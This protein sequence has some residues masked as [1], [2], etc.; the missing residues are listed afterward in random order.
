[1]KL[2]VLDLCAGAGG[3]SM[4]FHR[5]DCDVHGVEH[6]ADACETHRRMVGPCDNVDMREY[7]AR[8]GCWAMVIGGVPCQPHSEQGKKQGL[9]AEMGRLHQHMA[10]IAKEARAEAVVMENVPGLANA[11]R[12][13]PAAI[14]S[15]VNTFRLAGYVTSWKIVNAA[16]FGVPQRR[17]RVFVVGF[18]SEVAARRFRWPEPTHGKGAGLLPQVTVRQALKL[19]PGLFLTK[20]KHLDVSWWQGCRRIDVD[21]PSF[22]IGTRN[23]ADWICPV[24]AEAYRPRLHQLA[25]LQGFPEGFVFTGNE[26]AKHTQMGNACPPELGR[27]VAVQVR[28]ALLASRAK[29]A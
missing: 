4:G 5:A 1:M 11:R 29:E 22:V 13:Q 2:P 19:G 12:G 16:D 28:E 14:E 10:R 23:N 24:G 9:D 7:S 25:I 3:M 8:P 26:T 18:R 27:A 17:P 20:G 6:D 21:R 15:V